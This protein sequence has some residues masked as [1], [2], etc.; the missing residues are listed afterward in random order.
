M[1]N[2]LCLVLIGMLAGCSQDFA[3]LTFEESARADRH[4]SKPA[5]K[6][7]VFAAYKQAIVGQLQEQGIEPTKVSMRIDP[8]DDHSVIL[9]ISN[10]G[11]Q[12]EQLQAFQQSLQAIVEAREALPLTVTFN[13]SRQ[14]GGQEET[15]ADSEELGSYQAEMTLG[16]VVLSHSYGLGDML[17]AALTGNSGA[18]SSVFCNISVKLEPHLPFNYLAYKLDEDSE[19]G[20]YVVGRRSSEIL[21]AEL[22][23]NNARLQAML[24]NDEVG[25]SPPVESRGRASMFSGRLNQI[26]LQLGPV[27]D[28]RHQSGKI[29]SIVHSRLRGQ[30]SELAIGLGQPF[31]FYMGNTID[32]LTAVSAIEG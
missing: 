10:G 21:N 9:S 27:G 23:F 22:Q 19:E 12:P 25:I 13:L 8:D 4:W 2:L 17:A 14:P 7:E 1:R 24:D 26:D 30:C 11:A 16:R 5:S 15:E 18:R 6:P 32:R 28:V 3:R 31:S 29:D 20:R